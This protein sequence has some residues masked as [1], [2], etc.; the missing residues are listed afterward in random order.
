MKSIRFK[1]DSQGNVVITVREGIH[2]TLFTASMPVELLSD[3]ATD[4]GHSEMV[5]YEGLP[6]TTKPV[7]VAKPMSEES[8]YKAENRDKR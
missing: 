5:Q 3:F 7:H 1:K 2:T 4:K 6:T 8:Y